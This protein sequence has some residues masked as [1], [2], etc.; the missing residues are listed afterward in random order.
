[1]NL[2]TI[3]VI[4]CLALAP[5]AAF[6]QSSFFTEV[7]EVRITNVDVVVTDK[8]GKPVPG[9]TLEDFELYEDGVQKE[10]TNFLEMHENA[11]AA[12]LSPAGSTENEPAEQAPDIRRRNIVVFIDN[13]GIHPFRR[14][15]ILEHLQKFLNENLRT[16]DEVAIITWANS[17]KAELEPTSDRSQLE[18]TLRRVAAQSSFGNQQANDRR[19][20]EERLKALAAMY[21]ARGEQVPFSEAVGEARMYGMNV[22]HQAQARVEALKAVA[23][24][25]R[26]APGRK[27]LLFVT[28]NFS[29]NP[30][31][32]AFAYLDS[33]RSQYAGAGVALNEARDLEIPN[34]V[35]DISAAANSAGVS[36]YPIDGGGKD[37]G[38]KTVDASEDGL[39]AQANFITMETAQRTVSSIAAETGGFALTG[40]TNWQLAF[41]TLAN[42]LN[43]YY[44]LGYRSSGDRKDQ[45]KKIEVRLKNKK[46]NM[47]V[48]TRHAVIEPSASAEM[49]DAVAAYLFRE[50]GENVLAIRAIAGAA[51]GDEEHGVT[52]P[53]TV[54]IPT[55]KLTL[56]PEGTDLTGSFS[57]FAAFLRKDGAVSKVARQPQTF[58]FPADSLK[59]RKEI[60]VRIDVKADART[61]NISVGVLDDLSRATGFAAVRLGE[62]Q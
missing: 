25:M 22:R 38:M 35:E 13:A 48:R 1:M 15:V 9:L 17:L 34:V 16:G 3:A 5:A 2:K 47:Q 26:G 7:M 54:T 33:V 41:D 11:P 55:E 43:T 53:L 32:D 60:T 8:A 30:A 20:F 4:A 36:I 51:T 37:G 61:S 12:T 46:R 58:R 31:E 52:I 27:I 42:D 62:T 6:A 10:I 49:N 14:K 44:S 21:G 45:L 40:S 29:S 28:Q 56:L 19:L 23:A 18:S 24:S 59:R 57:V 50:V 39:M